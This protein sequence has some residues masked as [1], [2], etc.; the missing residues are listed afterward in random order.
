[1]VERRNDGGATSGGVFETRGGLAG[2]V[3]RRRDGARI[4]ASAGV[5]EGDE[6]RGEATV[7]N[8]LVGLSLVGMLKP[9]VRG[10]TGLPV[11]I[12]S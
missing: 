8:V 2:S 1:V 6:C 4:G 5:E 11:G 10:E 12:P 9:D 7:A 3:I